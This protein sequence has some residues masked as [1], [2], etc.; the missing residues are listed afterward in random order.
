[1]FGLTS[2]GVVHTAISLAAVVAGAIALFRF[3]RIPWRS[4]V[5]RVYALTTVLT[6]LTGFFIFQHGG[7][8]KPHILGIF[9]LLV[10]GAAFLG[11]RGAFG[12][13]APYVETIGLT[14]SF[15]L[16]FIP[17]ATETLIR[18]PPGHPLLPDAD[19]PQL[20]VIV[21]VLFL[22]FL[23]GAALQFLRLRRESAPALHAANSEGL[24]PTE[25]RKAGS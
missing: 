19:A 10:L 25:P 11:S 17:G 23:I 21:G 15:F 9:T 2:F 1:M 4:H 5:G 12:R 13:A 6:C 18:L 20:Q 8:G 24:G 16:H 3:G 14:F 22:L 7:F